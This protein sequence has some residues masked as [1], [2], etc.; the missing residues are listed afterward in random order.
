MKKLIGMLVSVCLLVMQPVAFSSDEI[1]P[2]LTEQASPAVVSIQA[3]NQ[4]GSGFFISDLGYILTN[5]HV[6][7][8]ITTVSVTLT[9]GDTISG[10]VIEHGK[11]DFAIIKIERMNTPNLRLGSSQN[12]KQGEVVLV[13]GSPKGLPNT[14]SKG[15]ISHTAR[16]INGTQYVQIDGTLNP[17]NS[18][19]PVLNMRGDVIGIATMTMLDAQGIGFV[20]PIEAVFQVIVEKGIPVNT[21]LSNG[22]LALQPAK[23][24]H[25]YPL[26]VQLVQIQWYYFVAGV[27]GVLAIGGLIFFV[28]RYRRNRPKSQRNG[29][30]ESDVSI[31][32]RSDQHKITQ[33][34]DDIDIK[35]H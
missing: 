8:D 24:S 35:L 29:H 15:M 17:G 6:V 23:E 20:L 33:N 32:L 14:V 12:A 11:Q 13:M 9:N 4:G 28:L 21:N 10:E 5:E 2:T 22:A 16:D 30:G 27:S 34:D 19:G 25:S 26:P 7:K 1:L 3:G 31:I 18:G